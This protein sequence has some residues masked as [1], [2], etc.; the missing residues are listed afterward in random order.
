MKHADVLGA[1]EYVNTAKGFKALDAIIKAAPVTVLSVR[2]VNPGR[3]LVFFTGD[4][5]SV[6]ASLAAG[7]AVAGDDLTD[8]LFIKNLHPSV[9]P[10]LSLEGTLPELDAVGVIETTTVIGGVYAADAAAKRADVRLVCIRTDSHMG[11]RASVK[12]TGELS[13]VEAA[14]E[15]GSAAAAERGTLLTSIIVPRP[16]PDIAPFVKE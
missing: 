3:Y 4:V 6:E 11:G 8:E 2:T 9:V 16:H 13:E 12:L 1:Q 14:V 5:A 15:A 7:K 10:A